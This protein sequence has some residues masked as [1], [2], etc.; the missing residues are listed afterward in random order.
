VTRGGRRVERW[1][2]SARSNDP[3]AVL[4]RLGRAVAVLVLARL[5]RPAAIL[6]IAATC[7]SCG[8]MHTP[9]A[10]K[11]P[12]PPGSGMARR[13]PAT[14]PIAA[15]GLTA[16]PPAIARAIAVAEDQRR[17]AD[18]ELRALLGHANPAVRSRA[19]LAVGRLQ[20]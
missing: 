5:V 10:V 17:Y 4:A 12:P 3:A 11:P 9:G 18:G 7:A 20:D 14:T 19:A 1:R 8:G 6:A 13:P 16:P 15:P 2:R